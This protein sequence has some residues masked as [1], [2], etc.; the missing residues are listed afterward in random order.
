MKSI[1]GYI[2]ALITILFVASCSD[3]DN[4][5]TTNATVSFDQA[6]FSFPE[7]AGFVSIPLKVEGERNGDIR[8]RLKV[9]DGTAISEGHYI[10]TSTEL[11]IPADAD[12]DISIEI[13][14]LDDG[15]QEN[16]DR[17]FNIAIESIDGATAGSI[18]SCNVILSDVDK[19]PYFKLFGN[20]TLTAIDATSGK[21]VQWDVKIWDEG[22]ED[23]SE[24][25]LICNGFYED[26]YTADAAWVLKYSASGTVD[27][28][29][30][31][32][33]YA[34]YNF[35]SF[36]GAVCV[37]PMNTSGRPQSG[38]FIPGTYN[39]TFDEIV[40]DK[41]AGL[42]GVAAYEYDTSTGAVGEY[43]G[44]LSVFQIIGMTKK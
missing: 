6:E 8:V 24:K 17:N 18:P 44:R 26:K 3:D 25:Y 42:V 36:I 22:D 40:F 14:V 16:D 12:K 7:S 5:N 20:W 35:G 33:F 29:D 27:I 41:S 19:N 21:E 10:V 32:Y 15:D 43:K 34:A 1:Y 39:N 13:R 23:N 31:G 4:M 11:N 28:V 9:T 38:L 37:T 30:V 2:L